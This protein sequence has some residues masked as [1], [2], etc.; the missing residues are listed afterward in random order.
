MILRHRSGP[1]SCPCPGRN[2]FQPTPVALT[3][4][5]L[6]DSFRIARDPGLTVDRSRSGR[7]NAVQT[8]RHLIERWDGE[9]LLMPR[10]DKIPDN[11][12]VI[13]FDSAGT[14]HYLRYS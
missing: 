7:N 13:A 5:T 6:A 3:E 4:D 11:L 12:H 8:L 10:M 1:I 2:G 9:Q 14:R